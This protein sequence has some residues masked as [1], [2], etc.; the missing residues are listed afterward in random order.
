MVYDVTYEC[1]SCAACEAECPRGAI[2]EGD[3]MLQANL[4]KCTEGSNRT[5]FCSM[6]A[7]VPR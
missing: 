3:S 1:F 2:S 6:E 7:C 4:T 5:T